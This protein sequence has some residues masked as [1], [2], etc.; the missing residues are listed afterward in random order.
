M[1]QSSVSRLTKE[2]EISVALDL[3]GSGSADIATGV[4]FFDHMLTQIARHGHID[5]TVKARGDT[6]I[7]PPTWANWPGVAVA[8]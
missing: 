7:D 1:R 3:D 8:V 5:L 6:H 4:G 2:T